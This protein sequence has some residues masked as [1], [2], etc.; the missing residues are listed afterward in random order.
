MGDTP[1]EEQTE[2]GPQTFPSHK[3]FGLSTGVGSVE[4]VTHLWNGSPV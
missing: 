2:L 3:F 1:F 4:I